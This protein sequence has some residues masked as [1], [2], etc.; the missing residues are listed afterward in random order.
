MATV[1]GMPLFI[2]GFVGMWFFAAVDACRTAQLMRSGLAPDAEEDAIARHLYGNP[3]AWSITLV[4]IGGIFLMHTMLGIT[5]PIR[6]IL[7]VALVG[8]GAYMLFDYIRRKSRRA[9][10]VTFD[11]QSPPRSVVGSGPLGSPRFRTG[12]L[13]GKASQRQMNQMR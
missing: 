3:L 5:L 9:D 8:L 13:S 11:P 7:P 12:D 10:A 4:V 2:L 6:R 1:T